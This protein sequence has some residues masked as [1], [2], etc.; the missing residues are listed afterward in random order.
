MKE[1]LISIIVPV[2]NVEKYLEECIESIIHQTYK[3]LEII[4]VDDGA[5]DHSGKMCDEFAKKDNRIKVIHKENGGLSDARNAGIEIATGEYIQFVDSDDCLNPKMC[6]ILYEEIK[7]TN[8]EISLCSYYVWTNDEKNTSATYTREI[9]TPE[10][11]LQEFLLDQKVKAYAWNKM[12]KKSLF[13]TIR[14]PVKRVFE[15]QLTI[16]ILFAMASKIALNNIPLYYYRQREGSILHNQTKTLRIAYIEAILEMQE[17]L[18]NKH[19]R[20][21]KYF[22]YNIAHVTMNTFNDAGLFKMYDLVE[23]NIVQEL[24]HKT[25]TIFENKEME[26][27]ILT[28]SSN[29]KKLH[30]YYLLEDQQRYIK[31]NKYLPAIYPEHKNLIIK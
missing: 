27:F 12:F 5:T 21:E 13:D 17:N 19:F 1:A 4:L 16:P 8:A 24:Y 30:Y 6:E 7:Q 26:Y 18:K 23:E 29:I 22:D 31:Y 3:N 10:Q 28:H 25:K 2:Y 14:F 9:Y 11:A 15:D 20:L